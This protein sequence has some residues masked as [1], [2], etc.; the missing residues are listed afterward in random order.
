MVEHV[1]IPACMDAWTH[2]HTPP[3]QPSGPEGCAPA[4]PTF[5]KTDLGRSWNRPWEWARGHLNS[6]LQDSR[7]LNMVQEDTGSWYMYSL[8]IVVL[9]AM[10][11]GRGMA[12]GEPEWAPS[13]LAQEPHCT[14]F[15][16]LGGW[17]SWWRGMKGS[18][19]QCCWDC[20]WTMRERTVDGVFSRM[21]VSVTEV[22]SSA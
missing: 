13:H 2:P 9:G 6:K 8:G 17:S 12:R 3:S 15:P 21:G 19:S 14:H 5:W 10:C 16:H 1:D 11:R 7:E 4:E 18:W 22:G 20:G